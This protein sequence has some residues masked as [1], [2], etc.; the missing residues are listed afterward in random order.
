MKKKMKVKFY[1][2]KINPYHDIVDMK[3]KPLVNLDYKLYLIFMHVRVKGR[4]ARTILFMLIFTSG[5]L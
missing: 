1:F 5:V 4:I 3:V 2:S